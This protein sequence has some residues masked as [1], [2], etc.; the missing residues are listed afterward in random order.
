MKRALILTAAAL[1][2]WLVMSVPV[3]AHVLPVRTA[4]AKTRALAKAFYDEGK[5]EF[6]FMDYGL[7]KLGLSACTRRTSHRLKCGYFLSGT[8]V[9]GDFYCNEV[10]GVYYRSRTSRR[11]RV[12]LE[13][14]QFARNACD[15]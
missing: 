12:K 1:A 2:A 15:R 6:G 7:R 9:F 10:S 13:S 11:I 4:K 8:D 14:S 3:Q 5:A